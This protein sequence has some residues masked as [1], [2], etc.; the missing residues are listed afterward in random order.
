MEPNRRKQ[1][2]GGIVLLVAVALLVVA[3]KA[4]SGDGS[5]QTTNDPADPG[6]S[7]SANAEKSQPYKDGTYSATGN[8]VSPGGTQTVKV[9]LDLKNNTIENAAVESLSTNRDSREFQSK[10]ISGFKPFVVGK[11]PD[12]IQISHV[13]GSSLTSEGFK[14]ALEKIKEQARQGS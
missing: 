11:D 14:N 2:A 1:I 6:T 12:D 10:F 3:V 13:S 8:Y 4:F 7:T 9:T 5:P